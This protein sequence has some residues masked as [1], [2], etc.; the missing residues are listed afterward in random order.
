MKRKEWLC[1]VLAMAL[2]LAAGILWPGGLLEKANDWALG[3]G[4]TLRALSLSG[5]W[6]A[7]LGWMLY[8]ALGLMP[9]AGLLPLH[10]RH[11]A[12][13]IL[14]VLASA[15]AFLM[16]YLLV[17]PFMLIDVMTPGWAWTGSENAYLGLSLLSPLIMLLLA[18]LVLRITDTAGGEQAL[19]WRIS[20]GL[21]VIEA[22]IVFAAA[23]ALPG[24]V[25]REMAE[26]SNL[27]VAIRRTVDGYGLF[28]ALCL[29]VQT[30]FVLGVC[31]AGRQLAL[32]ARS[33]WLEDESAQAARSLAWWARGLLAAE[34]LTA[35]LDNT[36]QIFL[37]AKLGS[38]SFSMNL[39]LGGVISAVCALLMAR[40][41][42]AGVRVR[43]ENDQFI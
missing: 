9:L 23:L 29:I 43:R 20:R 34:L 33:G 1:L 5:G 37:G 16:L 28:K 32:S 27:G 13:D 6:R 25:T 35:A 2:G 41:V 39:P 26:S 21:T 40:F 7:K 38:V 10:R 17:N 30:A 42:Q 22:A 8:G 18:A 36:V 4:E 19:I 31:R 14:W 11:G 15:Y 12:W 24:E 3:L